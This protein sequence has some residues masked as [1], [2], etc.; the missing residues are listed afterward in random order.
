MVANSFRYNSLQTNLETRRNTIRAVV[1][2]EPA[3]SLAENEQWKMGNKKRK[4]DT[5]SGSEE[6]Q[7]KMKATTTESTSA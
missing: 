3:A 5:K 7:K 1:S 6:A 4:Q 2:V